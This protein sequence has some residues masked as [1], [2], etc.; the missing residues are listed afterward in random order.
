MSRDAYKNKHKKNLESHGFVASE[1]IDVLK[2]KLQYHSALYYKFPY[3][4]EINDDEFDGMFR[5]LQELEE[6]NPHLVTPDSP[7]QV[8]GH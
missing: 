8:V 1:M 6:Q 2:I 4:V 3:L 7:T 5:L